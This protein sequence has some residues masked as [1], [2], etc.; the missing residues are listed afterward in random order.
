[1]ERWFLEGAVL[2][3]VLNGVALWRFG[4]WWRAAAIIPAAAMALALGVG[5][6]AALDGSNLAPIWVILAMPVCLAWMLLL[7]VARAAVWAIS[8]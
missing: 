5:V 7:W 6:L 3:L 4:G 2:W 1:M 8:R